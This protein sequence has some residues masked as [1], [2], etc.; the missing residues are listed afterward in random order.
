M[1]LIGTAFRRFSRDLGNSK[2]HVALPRRLM[3]EPLEQR[4]ML[5]IG[6]NSIMGTFAHGDIGDS[7]QAS[8]TVPSQP[9]ANLP[10]AARKAIFSAI[11]QDQSQA[12]LTA[13]DGMSG[14]VFG[15]SVSISGNTIVVGAVLADNSEG[16]AYVFTEPSSGWADMTQVARLTASDG[17]ASDEF[18]SSVSISGNTIVVGASEATIGANSQQ[19]AAY[20]FTEPASGWANMTQTAK[21]T[22]SDGTANDE[23]GV[24][25][26]ISGNTLVVGA[27][28]P[29]HVDPEGAAYVFAKPDSGWANMTQTAKL[30]ASDGT[31]NDFF[32][33]SVSISG[34]TVVV[35]AWEATVGAD[36]QQG[37]AYV[38]TESVSGW[39]NMTQT[40]KLIASGGAAYDYFGVSVSISSNTVVVGAFGASSQKGAAYV[41]AEPVSG[42][43]NMTKSAKLTASD[44]EAGD[45]FGISVSISGNTIVVGADNA[46]IGANSQQGAAYVFTQP[47]SG[48]EDMTETAK[49]TASDGVAGDYF[50]ISVSISGDT[51][52]VGATEFGESSGGGD[53][54]G[55]GGD[56]TG[57]SGDTTGGSGDT[58]GGSG[59]TTGG[60]GDT[61]GD[62]GDST[63]DGGGQCGCGGDTTD[64]GGDTTGDGGDTTGDGGD[65]TGDGGDSTGDGGDTT[66]D[67]GDTTGDGGDSTDDGSD[68]VDSSA[69]FARSV[70]VVRATTADA[71]V[72]A[73]NNQG[74]A[75]VFGTATTVS[76]VSTTAPANS[77]YTVD[78]TVPITVTFSGAVN[79]S[80]APQLTLGDGGVAN[81]TNGSGTATLTF[82][83]TVA[84][85][86][87][88]ADL[89]YAS[90]AALGLNGGS[91]QDAA[92]N[93]A[94]LTLPAASTDG[95]ATQ[96]V[97]ID[98]RTPNIGQ[99]IVDN[100]QPGFWSTS[101]STWNTGSGLDGSSLI[102]STPNGSKRSQAAW[103]FSMPAGVYE[104]SI[105]YTAGNNLTKDLGLDVYDGVGNW[106]GQ[107]PVNEQIAPH[108]FTEAGVAW[109][110]L[111]AFR[112]TNSIFHVSTWNSSSDGAI[113]VN[114]IQM[115]AAPVV[116]DSDAPNSY[117]YYPTGSIGSFT[118]S[119][120]WTTGAQ[121]AFGGSD[122]SS[123]TAGSGSSTARW[124]MPVT[125][126]SY[127]VDVTWPASASLSA[128]ATYNVYDGS[129][130]LGSVTVN[131]QTAPS[132]ISYE[133]L[134]WQS[135]GSFTIMGTQL[136]V[137]LANTGAD[138]QVDADAIR[139]LPAYQ[140]MP[141][142]NNG[143]PGFWSN[144][145]WATQNTGLYGDSLVSNSGNGSENSQAAW[146]FPVRPGEYEVE[147]TWVPGGNLSPI[148][149]LDV[150]NA[151]T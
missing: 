99:E 121:G 5:S 102:S 149:P 141:I 7:V 23:F 95:L 25:V 19:G 12:K 31:A 110:N 42:W 128:G 130:K 11:G 29:Y 132:G 111:G 100:S 98:T 86:Q 119:G 46:T 20:V 16:A 122:V 116:D 113:C 68:D 21:L 30:V 49:L 131:Q 63:D 62:G 92:G 78:G 96:N 15:M 34:N 43:A 65:T 54:S 24:S 59:D 40:A 125:P 129:T 17:A 76:E 140:P 14:D 53:T 38:F 22:A 115:Q 147:V 6:P 57:G 136:S 87:N 79:V 41:F 51:I 73:S 104:I 10:A 64:D 91:I 120:P 80:G 67:G 18:G 66:G 134:N 133:G 94:A 33:G 112:I 126:R 143:Y 123:G 36:S 142:V 74:A 108:S 103:W 138:G 97:T 137:T 8:S 69:L 61:T 148:A 75:Y 105:T 48:W 55:G 82:T 77:H 72:S 13:S 83:Y 89:D 85:G 71:N 81:Y 139:I 84:A 52:V 106:I 44:G 39:A 145:A 35:G 26:S 1:S 37:A 4:A 107:I 3:V 56:S 9:L 117:P 146:W 93:A 88:T 135:L 150:Y 151:L 101:S 2:Q 32:G 124:T 109:E 28:N 118:F 90:T 70:A 45:F 58:T 60:S 144:A 47:I 127:E 114:G 50:G 27:D